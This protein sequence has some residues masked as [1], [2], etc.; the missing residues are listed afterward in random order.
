[1][2][3]NDPMPERA[4]QGVPLKRL[5]WERF[6]GR[7]ELGE[8][9]IHLWR[10]G[11]DDEASLG[12]GFSCLSRE[13]QERGERFRF[14]KDRR[15]H[16][17]THTVKRL[18]LGAYLGRS[19]ESLRFGTGPWGKPHLM[20][21]HGGTSLEFNL[22]HSRGV[23]LIG[24]ARQPSLGVDVEAMQRVE[25]MQP[26]FRRFAS[27]FEQAELSRTGRISDE[28]TL[29]A[30]WVSKEAFVKAVGRGLSLGLD[31]FSLGM[32]DRGPWSVRKLPEEWGGDDDYWLI[33]FRVGATHLGGLVRRGRPS[34]VRAY[35][36][37]AG[38]GRGFQ[39]T[40]GSGG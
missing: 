38:L 12:G 22:S 5:E 33:L 34:R 28:L 1:M 7:L 30:W 6:S 8:N 35:Q 18:L 32:P 16:R 27:R 9:E 23:T 4:G 15:S 3:M 37:D 24:M 17:V 19:P 10:I 39:E 31:Q 14:E 20:E 21:G 26:I 11:V 29:T 36:W 13:E 2:L 25:R 40:G